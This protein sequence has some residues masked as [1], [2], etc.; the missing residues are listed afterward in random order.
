MNLHTFIRTYLSHWTI[1]S[2]CCCGTDCGYIVLR[3]KETRIKI[4][5][6]LNGNTS[7]AGNNVTI[8]H[9]EGDEW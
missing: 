6:N 7:W 9:F 2:Y 4:F 8:D 3:D 5:F 1:C